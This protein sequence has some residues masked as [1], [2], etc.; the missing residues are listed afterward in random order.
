MPL[1]FAVLGAAFLIAALRNKQGDLLTLIEGEFK[2]TSG[3]TN[4]AVWAL[5][6]LLVG[7]IGYVRQLKPISNGLLALLFIGIVLSNQGL[8]AKLRNWKP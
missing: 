8:I 6:L 4:F 2:G 3:G 5:A 1:F 7:G